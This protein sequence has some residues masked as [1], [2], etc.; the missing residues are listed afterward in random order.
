MGD[1]VRVPSGK[2]PTVISGTR[3]LLQDS[4]PYPIR[5][6]GIQEGNWRTPEAQCSEEPA[7]GPPWK[8]CGKLCS[9]VVSLWSA[10]SVWGAVFGPQL[11]GSSRPSAGK[12]S[13]G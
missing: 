11:S 10:L 3:A 2:K 9:V 1:R 6:V 7:K 8:S 4:Y 5:G 12:R 13:Q